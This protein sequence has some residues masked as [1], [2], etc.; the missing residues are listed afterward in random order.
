MPYADKHPL[1]IKHPLSITIL[2]SI[3]Q[4][5]AEQ[6]NSARRVAHYSGVFH[7]NTTEFYQYMARTLWHMTKPQRIALNRA[8]QSA[9]VSEFGEP[10]HK[11]RRRERRE[12]E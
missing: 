11:Q 5:G 3:I 1:H 12:H 6:H 2:R 10:A 9:S 7:K 4:A 8:T